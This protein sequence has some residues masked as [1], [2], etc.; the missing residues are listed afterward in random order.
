MRSMKTV[1][2]LALAGAMVLTMGGTA[3]AA[4]GDAITEVELTKTV[5]CDGDTYAPNTTFSFQLN[6]AAAG[7]FNGTVTYAG[8][9][10]G[11]SLSSDNDFS[12]APDTLSDSYEKTGKILVDI[13][14]FSAPGIYHYTISEV[15][16]NYEGIVYDTAARDLYV[17]VENGQSGLAVTSII[18]MNGSAK[19]D[20][21]FVNDYGKENDTTHDIT[22]TKEVTGNQGDRNKLFA[23]DVSVNGADGEKYKVVVTVDGTATEYSITSGANPVTYQ[24]SDGDTI[25]IFGLTETDV[26]QVNEQDYSAD[27]Y[28]TTNRQNSGSVCAD[29][30]GIIVTN[31]KEVPPSTGLLL[32]AAPFALMAAAAGGFG[33]MIFGRRRRNEE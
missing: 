13:S 12:F 2:A 15:A 32:S 10:G 27:G 5:T 17:Y 18:A 29:A 1:S 14:K 25:Q 9:A 7:T 16:G 3:F 11:L 23:F 30:S 8:V 24:I 22:F 21:S 28:T 33:A 6:S 20:L 19:E 4:N 31:E 26:Y